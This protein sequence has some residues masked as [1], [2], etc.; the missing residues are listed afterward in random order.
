MSDRIAREISKRM[1]ALNLNPLSTAK[2]AKLG[3]DAIR[4]IL[5]GKNANPSLSTL[6]KIAKALGC[7]VADL[8]GER[9]APSKAASIVVHELEVHAAAGMGTDGDSVILANEEAGAI[10]GTFTFPVA[11]FREMV[12][13]LPEN[14]RIIAVRGDSMQPTLFPGQRVMVDIGDKLP[15]PPGIFVVWDGL[16]LVIK[17]VELVVGSEPARV[18][19]TSDNQRYQAYERTLD[20]AHINGRIIGVW[21]RM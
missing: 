17:R 6:T 9:S 21:A 12:P 13:G 11:G 16:A 3:D 19:L 5:R 14:V 10:V 7:A 8:T 20:E 4:D 1:D 2:K 15:S 18:R